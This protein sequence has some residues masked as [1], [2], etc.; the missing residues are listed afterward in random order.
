MALARNEPPGTVAPIFVVSGAFLGAL[1]VILFPVMQRKQ[2]RSS[3][4]PLVLTSFRMC[5]ET[6]AMPSVKAK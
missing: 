1:S 6:A 3:D 2:L 5:C 4:K